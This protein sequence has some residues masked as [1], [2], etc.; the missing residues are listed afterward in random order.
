MGRSGNRAGN[1]IFS[2][3][4]TVRNPIR[5]IDF[6]KSFQ[7][8]E[9]IDNSKDNLEK[10][11][12]ELV[13]LG[14]YKFT[15]I[16]Q[17]IKNKLMTNQELEDEE[18]KIAFTNN[19]QKT[20]F[21]GRVMTQLRALKDQG[22]IKF[23][24]TQRKY[25][26]FITKLG[27]ELI[28]NKIP[29]TDIYTKSMIGTH[30]KNPARTS[31]QNKSRPFLNTLFVINEVNKKWKNGEE[32]K[33]IL[34]HEFATFVLSMKDCDYKKIANEIIEYR[35]KYG[36]TANKKFIE[37]Y[38]FV[39]EEILPI[40][41]ESLIKDYAD[42][43]FRKFQMTNLLIK[44]GKFKYMYINYSEYNIK[45]IES[46]LDYYKEYKFE[47][48]EDINSYY[49]YLHEIYLPWSENESIRIKV[50]KNK[51]KKLGRRITNF[52]NL[53]EVEF[54]LD[55]SHYNNILSSIIDKMPFEVIYAELE[56]LSGKNN[57]NSKYEDV[58]E[59]LR[60]E[61]FLAI[62]MGKK[63]GKEEIVSNI[64][65]SEEGKP[66]SFA[67][68]GQ[69]DM[70]YDDKD[71]PLI[72]EPTMAKNRAQQLNSETTNIVR[73]MKDLE[74][75]TKKQY[76]TMMIAPFVHIDVISYF[77]FEASTEGVKL[78]PITINL[79]LKLVS[80]NK[81]IADFA[82]EFDKVV[83]VLTNEDKNKYSLMVNN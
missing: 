49:E 81:F 47:E 79:F 4:T 75:K 41:Y 13:K 42:D 61:Y 2:F 80:N 40:K 73:H 78:A 77:K 21:T 16:S 55:N 3:N 83:E 12:F 10:Y 59:P 50:L 25:K 34:M 18:V 69:V 43:V 57:A 28:N 76:R 62:L 27:H 39:K 7:S 54:R 29:S 53:N 19:P 72:M 56:I 17:E 58:S 74:L 60:L 14:I 38:L 46:L 22:F 31:L 8:F 44:H 65:Y 64:I 15:N 30:S 36:K 45:K 51:A 63:Y 67:P 70:I 23:V 24:G 82:K 35:K 52:D 68:S 32:P 66:L 6:L 11:L 5:N 26:I 48:F 1:K 37:D 9:G 20:N 71:Y 33:G